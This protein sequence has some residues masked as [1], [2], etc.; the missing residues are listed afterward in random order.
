MCPPPSY[1]TEGCLLYDG[2][3]GYHRVG[4]DNERT[5]VEVERND[6]LLEEV[7]EFGECIRTGREPE[8]TGE[9]ALLALAVVEGA[10]RSDAEGRPIE[11]A[12]LLEG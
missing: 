4:P 10:I 7:T 6:S 8:V 1:G 11:I 12:E 9:V 3:L 5:P 2:Y